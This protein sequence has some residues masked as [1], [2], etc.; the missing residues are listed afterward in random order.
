M[1]FLYYLAA[2]ALAFFLVFF[3]LAIKVRKR[4]KALTVENIGAV[5]TETNDDP[6]EPARWVP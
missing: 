5:M 4:K 1:D 6:D 2:V 3:A